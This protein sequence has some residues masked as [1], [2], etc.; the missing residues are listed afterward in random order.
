MLPKVE[1]ISLASK[2]GRAVK[3]RYVRREMEDTQNTNLAR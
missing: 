3:T 2:I 1:V